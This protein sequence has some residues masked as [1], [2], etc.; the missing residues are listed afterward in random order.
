MNNLKYKTYIFDL[1]GTLIDSM[2]V[3]K[4]VDERFL[5]ERGLPMT[6]EYIDK[7]K[8]SAMI[9]S[10]K[11]TV[12]LYNLNETPEEVM[13]CWNDM[14]SKAYRE[15]IKLK[16]GALDYLNILDGK[17]RSDSEIKLA[18]AT[19]LP[20]LNA[21]A[22]LKANKILDRFDVILTLDDLE[23]GIDKSKPD[24]Y[25]EVLK[26]IRDDIGEKEISETVIFE[27]VYKAAMGAMKGGFDV[28]AV[29]DEV[30]SANDWTQMQ[31]STRYAIKNWHE[32]SAFC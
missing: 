4:E 16:P 25:F 6:R 14:V 1:D 9:D 21:E 32:I 26:R 23:N 8:S 24:I 5:S 13:K 7:V 3:W 15:E 17:K 10:A 22:V 12:E 27:D 29:F 11:F 18:V 19:A 2:N 31:K 28:C 20:Y 30:G